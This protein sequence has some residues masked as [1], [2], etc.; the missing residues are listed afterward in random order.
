MSK[1]NKFETGQESIENVQNLLQKLLLAKDIESEYVLLEK[2]GIDVN[3]K[4]L[5]AFHKQKEKFFTFVKENKDEL[6]KLTMEE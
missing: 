1:E 4:D 6:L 5:E 2:Y 3:K